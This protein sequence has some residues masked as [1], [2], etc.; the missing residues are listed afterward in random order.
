MFTLQKTE[1]IL[2]KYQKKYQDAGVITSSDYLAKIVKT[3]IKKAEKNYLKIEAPKTSSKETYIRHWIIESLEKDFA[4]KTLI[5]IDHKGTY[6]EPYYQAIND[7]FSLL[8]IALIRRI[9]QKIN[10]TPPEKRKKLWEDLNFPKKEAEDKFLRLILTRIDYFLKK[11][12]STPL[13]TSIKKFRIPSKDFQKFKENKEKIIK[14]YNLLLPKIG[15]LPSWFYSEFNLPCFICQLSGFPFKSI[16][17]VKDLLF[18]KYHSLAAFRYKIRITK[19]EPS[20]IKYNKTEDSFVITIDKYSNPRHQI[21]ILIHEMSHI[22]NY[23]KDFQNGVS[24][25]EQGR[26][27]QEKRAVETEYSIL[28]DVSEDLFR[29]SL[30]KVLIAFWTTFFEM[31]LYENP[32]QDIGKLYA[33]TFNQCFIEAKQKRNPFFVLN[34]KII[35]QPFFNLP[36]VVAYSKILEPAILNASKDNFFQ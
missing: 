11:E 30:G 33:N 28:K 2:E 21:M 24:Y 32:N 10:N 16:N 7:Y 8:P 15:K 6:S 4:K 12:N 19:G 3:N 17:Q 5:K 29:A 31:E 23:L 26:Y 25:L 36:Y 9:N 20:F 34:E 13:E 27:A 18:K 14:Q 35:T 22:I 1:E